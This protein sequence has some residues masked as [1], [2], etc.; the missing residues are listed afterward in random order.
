LQGTLDALDLL[1]DAAYA[2]GVTRNA[3]TLSSSIKQQLQQTAVSP[4]LA[5]FMSAHARSLQAEAAVLAAGGWDAAAG[6]VEIEQWVAES[7]HPTLS[8]A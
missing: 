3:G 6:G 1:F 8:K 7:P 2:A 4:Q 5:A